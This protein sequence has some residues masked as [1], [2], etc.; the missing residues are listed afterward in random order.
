MVKTEGGQATAAQ[1]QQARR[2]ATSSEGRVR[3]YA[4]YY[5]VG[6]S[7]GLGERAT[8]DMPALGPSAYTQFT[9]APFSLH[10]DVDSKPP[11]NAEEFP[12]ASLI[13]SCE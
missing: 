7:A 13:L 2:A 3:A 10:L 6:L 8:T 1:Q 12:Q 4:G 5:A 11:H 9:Q